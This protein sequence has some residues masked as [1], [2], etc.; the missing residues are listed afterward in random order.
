MNRFALIVR[1]A[2]RA[3]PTPTWSSA[4]ILRL[5]RRHLP[6][7]TPPP[8]PPLSPRPPRLRRRQRR[9][10]AWLQ[11]PRGHAFYVAATSGADRLIRCTAA[12]ETGP[13]APSPPHPPSH[14]ARS[15]TARVVCSPTN[16]TRVFRRFPHALNRLHRF[17]ILPAFPPREASATWRR[18]ARRRDHLH[19]ARLLRHNALG[20]LR[21][22][23]DLHRQHHHRHQ[24][25]S[26]LAPRHQLDHR[27]RRR[28]PRLRACCWGMLPMLGGSSLNLTTPYMRAIVSSGRDPCR[29]RGSRGVAENSNG[30]ARRRRCQPVSMDVT[31]GHVVRRSIS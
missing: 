10:R 14:R 1:L 7:S 29:C 28:R 15:T 16:E 2:S 18:P 9:R 5:R 12:G 20:H 6:P 21:Q 31:G 13:A 24:R 11:T 26:G 4:S 3:S 23:P 17:Q 30:N 22:R 19:A 8:A 27:R 25:R